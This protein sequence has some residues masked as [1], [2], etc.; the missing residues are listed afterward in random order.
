MMLIPGSHHGPVHDEHGRDGR[1]CG[2]IGPMCR[3]LDYS[4]A[5]P[6]LGK[7]GT[8]TVHHVCAVHGSATNFSGREHRLL[9]FQYRAAD[10]RPLLGFADGIGISTIHRSPAA[11]P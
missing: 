4:R 5:V 2:A 10:A 3:D 8:V 7:A 6:C 11:Q 1:F 9:L